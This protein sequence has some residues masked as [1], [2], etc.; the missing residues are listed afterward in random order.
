MT[1]KR[2]AVVGYGN[3]GKYSIEAIEA[4]PDFELAGVIRRDISTEK[5]RELADVVVTDDI[6]TL[7]KVDAALLCTP[8]RSV[9]E[10]AKKYLKLGI[11]TVDS[12][13]IH[14]SFLDLRREL[15]PIAQENNAVSII[16]SGWDPGSDSVVRTLLEA[17]APKGLTYTN[18]G[19]GM[20]M[21]HT[22]VAKSVGGVANALS[23]TIPLGT[24]IH[25][26]VVYVELAPGADIED[27]RKIIKSDPYFSHDET[28]V[29]AVKNIDDI[30]DMGH[31]VN[32][33]RKGVSG[34]TDNQLFE[35]S[36]RI[37]NPAL[38]SQIMV[39]CARASFRQKPGVYT[40]PE[41][42]LI[43]L[44]YGDKESLLARLV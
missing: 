5:P 16:S 14:T 18:F 29:I 7:G 22:V 39:A 27:V 1:K 40:M 10:H 41:I 36:M 35:F 30:I 37:N 28:H 2:I 6:S 42:P 20:S 15:M 9:P 25:R 8:T 3:I 21:G 33:V 13:D 11:N 44:L 26:R 24:S 43:D 19:P 12:Y 4:S 34:K 17:C 38:T 23:M 31:G 32:L